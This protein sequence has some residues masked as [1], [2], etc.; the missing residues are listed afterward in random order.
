MLGRSAIQIAVDNENTELVELLLRQDG[1]QIGD[2]LLYAIREGVYRI[3]EVSGTVCKWPRSLVGRSLEGLTRCR[4]ERCKWTVSV[5]KIYVYV[6]R[7]EVGCLMYG[8]FYKCGLF[9]FLYGYLYAL[10]ENLLCRFTEVWNVM[11]IYF[12]I[13]F[14]ISSFF[15]KTCSEP[16]EELGSW[17]PSCIYCIYL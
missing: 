12:V 1:V 9:I 14:Y 8:E 17:G 6:N 15:K 5:N 4:V 3:V 16:Y 7:L 11:M 2:A 10:W 13:P